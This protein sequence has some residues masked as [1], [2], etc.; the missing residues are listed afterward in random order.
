M[1]VT[2]TSEAGAATMR[3]REQVDLK[4]DRNVG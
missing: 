3:R 1:C 4:K 2:M